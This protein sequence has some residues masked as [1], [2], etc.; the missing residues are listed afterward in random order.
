[1][2]QIIRTKITVERNC[3]EGE[4]RREGEFELEFHHRTN[5]SSHWKNNIWGMLLNAN[6]RKSNYKHKP[7]LY[8]NEHLMF[9]DNEQESNKR[10]D[11][12]GLC[13]RGNIKLSTEGLSCLME[14]VRSII[15]A[16]NASDQIKIM[17]SYIKRNIS[18]RLHGNFFNVRGG[19]YC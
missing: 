3:T 4:G 16:N 5:G 10:N 1:M 6:S 18:C 2:R 17:Q 14:C 15:Y 12:N 19:D 11:D 8:L 9:P 13:K 7:L